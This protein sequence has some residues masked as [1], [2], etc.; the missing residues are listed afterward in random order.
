MPM[1]IDALIHIPLPLRWAGVCYWRRASFWGW[2][3]LGWLVTGI[4]VSVLVTFAGADSL[5]AAENRI[6]GVAV[7]LLSAASDFAFARSRVREPELRGFPVVPTS[8]RV[9]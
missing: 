1:S 5:P 9:R 2:F 6:V 3:L 8:T 7:H 4:F